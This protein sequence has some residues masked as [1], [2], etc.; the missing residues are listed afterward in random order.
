M[1]LLNFDKARKFGFHSY[2]D[3]KTSVLDT[4]ERMKRAGA[5]PPFVGQQG[6]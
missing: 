4:F 6:K 1:I 2:I 3:P 5:L